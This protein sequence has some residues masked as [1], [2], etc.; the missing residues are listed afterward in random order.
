V[1]AGIGRGA[2]REPG[3]SRGSVARDEGA[4]EHIATS[5]SDVERPLAMFAR[6]LFGE[7]FAAGAGAGS[8]PENRSG[9]VGVPGS[10]VV[11]VPESANSHSARALASCAPARAALLP[12]LRAAPP[13]VQ[14]SFANSL[15][16]YLP[17]SY[18]MLGN[19]AGRRAYFA[20]LAHLAA[21]LRF[22]G[23]PASPGDIK[24]IT[25]VLVSLLE[26]A[27]VEWLLIRELPGL[28]CTWREFHIARPSELA[29]FPALCAR[30]SR[31][32]FDE[33]YED[34]HPIVIKARA[35]FWR[36]PGQPPTRDE[37]RRIGS[38]LGNDVG[39]MR[40][41]LNARD[42]VVMPI[43]RD[44]HQLQWFDAERPDQPMWFEDADELTT[45]NE[46]STGP[47]TQSR[48]ML[49]APS[50][51]D[52]S[53]QSADRDLDALHEFDPTREQWVAR[54][55][56][57]G[58]E[59]E[60]TREPT[61][62]LERLAGLERAARER[63]APG[64]QAT[65][66]LRDRVRE[67]HAL[68]ESDVHI[69][70]ADRGERDGRRGAG[71]TDE[72]SDRL[73]DERGLAL[74]DERQPGRTVLHP[75]WDYLIRCSRPAFCT[76]HERLASTLSVG[77]PARR[78]PAARDREHT[79]LRRQLQPLARRLKLES[80]GRVRRQTDGDAL[81]LDAAVD[82]SLDLRA[83]RTPDDRVYVRTRP[84]RQSFAVLLLLDL[85]QSTGDA[86][87]SGGSVLE[88]EREA[89]LLW[90]EL[91]AR[92]GDTF[93]IAGFSSNGR[94]QVEYHRFKDVTEVWSVAHERRL[95]SLTPRLST[96]MGAALRH[97]GRDLR[98]SRHDHRLVLL[99]TDGE[100]A[101]IDAPDP[102]YLREDARHAVAELRRQS[103]QVFALSLDPAADAYVQAIFGEGRY[104]VLDR[105]EAL[106]RVLPRLY[107]R[108][109][110]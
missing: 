29:T 82:A 14:R 106:P 99:L 76:V 34:P 105:I 35:L 94:H 49:Q 16:L 9:V 80:I 85:S 55:R 59:L 7:G 44:D 64:G 22:G 52:A 79:H 20:A 83:R 13:G 104:W 5:F 45:V 6:G 71:R 2:V 88:L 98:A 21:H 78:A 74:D 26:D 43:Y 10:A 62:V 100:P 54:E 53:R 27:R 66:R 96:R 109:A 32:L 77:A 38:L 24:P 102:R 61:T 110:K 8:F 11:G 39:Q 84:R 108:L 37:C 15:G 72:S 50:E 60:S 68:L 1:K 48:E 58:L 40:L 18:P 86:L 47:D 69:L 90:A 87:P 56:G 70:A 65:G 42:Y 17:R 92:S 51:L 41:T 36:E 30:L 81:D 31:A 101:D 97:A 28:F 93:A 19:S 12:P 3:E 75:E 103:I 89:C 57:A 107:A 4:T 46:Q 95:D 23:P 91:L 63:D 67:M 33:T 25:R 73:D